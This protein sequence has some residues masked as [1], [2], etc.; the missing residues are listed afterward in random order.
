MSIVLTSGFTTSHTN[1]WTPVSRK[2]KLDCLCLDPH[3][4]DLSVCCLQPKQQGSLEVVVQALRFMGYP[5]DPPY[6]MS[7]SVNHL[8]ETQSEYMHTKL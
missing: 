6:S 3:F 2:E 1:V 4:S 5:E 8:A 7:Q